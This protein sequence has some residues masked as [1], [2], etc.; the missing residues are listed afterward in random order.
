MA[1]W[2][3]SALSECCLLVKVFRITILCINLMKS[4]SNVRIDLY[5]AIFITKSF[6]VTITMMISIINNITWCQY[7]KIRYWVGI[8]YNLRF[9]RYFGAKKFCYVNFLF[10]RG[11]SLYL[12]NRKNLNAILEPNYGPLVT[13]LYIKGL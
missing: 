9:Q 8:L 4:V 12:L 7:S 1:A 5:H 6:I 10:M 3:R 2:R 11:K 13:T